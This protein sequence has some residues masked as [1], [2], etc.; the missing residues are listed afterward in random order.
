MRVVDSPQASMGRR[1][2][3]DKPLKATGEPQALSWKTKLRGEI[4]PKVSGWWWGSST[5]T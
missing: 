3:W 1:E 2:K 5:T 4:L